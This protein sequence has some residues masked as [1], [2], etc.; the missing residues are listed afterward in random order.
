MIKIQC[1]K[2]LIEKFDIKIKSDCI[3]DELFS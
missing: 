1:T 3:C 2:K